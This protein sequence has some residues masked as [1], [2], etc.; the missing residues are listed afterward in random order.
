[1]RPTAEAGKTLLSG[2]SFRPNLSH[3]VAEKC[4]KTGRHNNGDGRAA[5]DSG[6]SLELAAH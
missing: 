4:Q 3:K 5:I 1:M 2:K 6:M